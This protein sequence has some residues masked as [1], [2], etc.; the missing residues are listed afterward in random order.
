MSRE[1]RRIPPE[2]L[3]PEDAD[4]NDG[5]ALVDDDGSDA[6]DGDPDDEAGLDAEDGEEGL[7]AD[8]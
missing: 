2:G 3:F 1:P 4:V 5:D 7:P 6:L 8:E